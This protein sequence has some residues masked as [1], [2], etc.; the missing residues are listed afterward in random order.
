M[1]RS[2][3]RPSFSNPLF[4]FLVNTPSSREPQCTHSCTALKRVPSQGEG[5]K[6]ALYV[7]NNFKIITVPLAR[8]GP[9]SPDSQYGAIAIIL[10]VF[11]NN[12]EILRRTAKKSK[13][14]QRTKKK[15]QKKSCKLR[16][17]EGC[18]RVPIS[19]HFLYTLFAF[20]RV[21]PASGNGCLKM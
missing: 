14:E 20:G 9:P 8:C 2:I 16:L 13:E 11:Y 4:T 21:F 5:S 6:K 19:R 12:Y 18:T 3:D 10:P 7:Y 15:Q 1:C 17:K